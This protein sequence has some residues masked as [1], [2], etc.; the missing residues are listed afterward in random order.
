MVHNYSR[1]HFTTISSQGNIYR[2][3]SYAGV[4]ALL[5]VVLIRRIPLSWFCTVMLVVIIRSY[6]EIQMFLM[7]IGRF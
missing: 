1:N 2:E 5:K 6:F 7:N 4:Q 3:L